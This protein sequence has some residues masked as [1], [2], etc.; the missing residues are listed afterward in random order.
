MSCNF[1]SHVRSDF[2]DLGV[3]NP[4]LLSLHVQKEGSSTGPRSHCSTCLAIAS[5]LSSVR[6]SCWKAHLSF[7]FHQNSLQII[8]E[9]AKWSWVTDVVDF[10]NQEVHEWL[11]RSTAADGKI[12]R[13]GHLVHSLG[14]HC[15]FLSSLDFEWLTNPMFLLE[16]CCPLVV[17]W[18]RMP[19]GNA[20]H[21]LTILKGLLK[22]GKVYLAEMMKLSDIHH[23]LC[24][25]TYTLTLPQDIAYL[26]CSAGLCVPP[27][28]SPS[29]LPTVQHSQPELTLVFSCRTESNRI[30]GT[31]SLKL[32]SSPPATYLC[33]FSNSSR[34][35][36]MGN[37]GKQML[38]DKSTVVKE[39]GSQSSFRLSACGSD[40]SLHWWSGKESWEYLLA[41][42]RGTAKETLPPL[43][44]VSWWGSSSCHELLWGHR[45][46]AS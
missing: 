7:P 13:A 27:Y 10:H 25:S 12:A 1:S 42:K 6:G 34:G 16:C 29:G 23:C 45:D 44:Q 32:H 20:V 21:W 22:T 24:S 37:Q 2:L 9:E 18:S 39:S 3:T 36:H 43:E 33:I 8:G 15:P 31:S 41:L 28:H 17:P 46:R 40:T 11:S 26:E 14:L 19:A 38:D 35:V 30:H 5:S 4:K